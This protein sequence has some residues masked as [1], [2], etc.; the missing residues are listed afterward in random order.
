MTENDIPDRILPAISVASL[1]Q[2]PAA[3]AALAEALR[4]LSPR[5]EIILRGRFREGKLL[6]E[7]GTL[8]AVSANRIRQIQEVALRKLD[9]T[10]R[11][12]LL[13]PALDKLHP[14]HRGRLLAPVE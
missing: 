12:R 13:A 10:H 2:D 11:E 4:A 1:S 9:P 3:E 6:R 8:F 5:E 14:V 7:L